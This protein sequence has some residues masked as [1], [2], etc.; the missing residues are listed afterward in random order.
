MVSE[1]ET[2]KNANSLLYI[3]EKKFDLRFGRNLN[4]ERLRSTLLAKQI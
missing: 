4:K 2:T 1:P 3:I